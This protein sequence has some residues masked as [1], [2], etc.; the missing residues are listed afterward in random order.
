MGSRTGAW[1]SKPID[2]LQIS[3]DTC[4]TVFGIGLSSDKRLGAGRPPRSQANK[5]ARPTV[6]EA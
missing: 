5:F 1:L 2:P 6:D 4:L 3:P